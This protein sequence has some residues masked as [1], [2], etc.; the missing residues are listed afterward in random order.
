MTVW[1]AVEEAE[2]YVVGEFVLHCIAALRETTP[3]R[4][5]KD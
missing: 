1:E 2:S 3:R 4:W 5:R